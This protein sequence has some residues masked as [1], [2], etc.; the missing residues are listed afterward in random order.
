MPS[1]I[2]KSF[3]VLG[4]SI[5]SSMLGVG[6]VAPLLPLYAEDM[7]A[8]GIW[9]GIIFG[10]F[11][12]SRA[13]VMPIMGR[14]SDRVGRKLILGAGLFAYSVISLGYLWANTVGVLSLVRFLHGISAGMIMPIA[15]AYVGDIVPEGEEGKWMGYANAAFFTGFGCGPLM[16]GVL[17]EH[18]GMDVAFSWVGC[19]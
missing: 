14:L 12:I 6:I 11:S 9:L 4:L 16:G 5:F 17:T 19:Y 2:K 8:T 15:Q 1:I 18:F 7:G 10:G 13:I 3:P